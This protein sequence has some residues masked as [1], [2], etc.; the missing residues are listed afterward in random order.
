MHEGIDP[1]KVRAVPGWRESALFDD[2]ERAVLEYAEA[3]TMT[4]AEVPAGCAERL[5]RH[6]SD[7]EI[8]ELAAWVALENF[9]SRF[10]AGLGLRSQG[11][12]EKCEVPMF[13]D[14]AGAAPVR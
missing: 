7:A 13:A 4:P 2:R 8:V 5:R 3:A 6:F 10:N 9:R 11:F 14:A 12:A 1:R